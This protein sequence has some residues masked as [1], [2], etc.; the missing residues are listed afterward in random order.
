MDNE[1]STEDRAQ[2]ELFVQSHPDLAEELAMLQQ[3]QVAPDA[4]EVYNH[5]ETLM[6]TAG[7]SFI[8]ADNYEECLLLYIDNELNS[9][10]RNAV[11]KFVAQ[12]I[13]AKKELDLLLKTKLQPEAGSIYFNKESLYRT[14]EKERRVI[15]FNWRRLA[16]AAIL[17]FVVGGS[18][19]LY[20]TTKGKNTEPDVASVEKGIKTP[21]VIAKPVVTP[22]KD[23][24]PQPEVAVTTNPDNPVAD[25][26]KVDQSSSPSIKEANEK[27]RTV[28]PSLQDEQPVLAFNTDINNGNDLPQPQSTRNIQ[29]K[30]DQPIAFTDIKA[31][32]NQ[33]EISPS[34]AV[35]LPVSPTYNNQTDEQ[36]EKKNKLRGLLRKVTRTIEKTTNIKATD[37]NDRLLV[38]GLAIQL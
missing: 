16:A 9:D 3:T 10:Q 30:I 29:T 23:E 24:Q 28:T 4:T 27:K 11:Q 6:M 12:H 32:T 33:K 34:F 2:V 22:T 26:K 15:P 13:I 17:L 8:N 35:T 37:E 14:E 21:P 18:A 38:G 5:K 7:Q 1:L 19:V 36:P 31:L 20:F 25:A